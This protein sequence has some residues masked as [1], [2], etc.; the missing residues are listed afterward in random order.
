MLPRMSDLHSL[1]SFAVVNTSATGR[2][3]QINACF[4]LHTKQR[5]GPYCELRR[6]DTWT[7]PCECT[8][9]AKMADESSRELSRLWRILR[10]VKQ[11]CADRVR[12]PQQA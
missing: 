12:S 11:M 10:T 6:P 8:H 3:P 2:V 1:K 7:K 9:S 5:R 4:L